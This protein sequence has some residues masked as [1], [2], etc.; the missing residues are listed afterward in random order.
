MKHLAETRQNAALARPRPQSPAQNAPVSGSAAVFTWATDSAPVPVR[1]QIASDNAFRTL[2]FDGDVGARTDVTLHHVLPSDGTSYFWRLAVSDTD[3]WSDAVRFRADTDEAYGLYLRAEA[4]RM[5][6]QM[7]ETARETAARLFR[8]AD[9]NPPWKTGMTSKR[10]AAVFATGM[11]L[12]FAAVIVL[13]AIL[14]H[15]V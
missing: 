14:L 5:A 9:A 12:S 15:R 11:V 6:A 13:I 3:E 1:L 4:A 10:E 7:E 2:L 8:E